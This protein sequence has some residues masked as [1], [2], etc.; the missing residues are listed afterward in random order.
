MQGTWYTYA[1]FN[2]TDIEGLDCLIS[3]FQLTP[4]GNILN[5]ESAKNLV[6]NQWVSLD[7]L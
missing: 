1:A 4:D 7:F 3:I 5:T 6:T 2:Y